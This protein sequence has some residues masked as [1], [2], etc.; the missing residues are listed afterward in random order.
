MSIEIEQKENGENRFFFSSSS[1]LPPAFL[2]LEKKTLFLFVLSFLHFHCHGQ[3]LGER[4]PWTGLL[5]GI[6]PIRKIKETFLLHLTSSFF[7]RNIQTTEGDKLFWFLD[8]LR[9]VVP[10]LLW[11]WPPI[12]LGSIFPFPSRNLLFKKALVMSVQAAWGMR[13]VIWECIKMGIFT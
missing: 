10:K 13:K 2:C 12:E 3:G 8:G 1:L 7:W 4:R 6:S 11:A 9:P 5:T